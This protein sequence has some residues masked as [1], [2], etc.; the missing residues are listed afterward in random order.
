MGVAGPEPSFFFGNLLEIKRRGATACFEEWIKKYGSICGFYNGAIPFLL[1]ADVD[2]LKKVELEDCNAFMDRG[3]VFELEPLPDYRQKMIITA[4]VSRWREMRAVLSP[5]FTISKLSQIFVIM[6]KCSDTMMEKLEEKLSGNASV[7]ITSAFRRATIDTM[8][9]AGYGVDLKVQ[10]SPP[11]GFFDELGRG[12]EQLLRT[13]PVCGVSFIANCFPEFYHFWYLLSWL[14]S[15]LAVPFFMLTAKLVCPIL[16]ERKALNLGKFTQKNV[17]EMTY[18]DMVLNESMR[19]YPG[20]VGFVSR[21]PEKDYE[22]N[23]MKIPRGLSVMAAV[24]CIHQDPELWSEPD[25]FDPERFNPE[26]KPNIHPISFQP[27]GKGPRA[28]LGRNFALLEMKL[29]LSKV[30][31]RFKVSVDE[32]HH[33]CERTYASVTG[34][35]VS[36]DTADLLMDEADLEEATPQA[37]AREAQ[38]STSSSVPEGERDKQQV[39]EAS[40][41]QHEPVKGVDPAPTGRDTPPDVQ[42]PVSATE[43]GEERMDV[44]RD[45]GSSLAAK[46]SHE[47]TADS[48]PQRDDGGGGEPPT[49]TPGVRRSPYRPR[50]NIPGEPRRAGNPPP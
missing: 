13:V 18:L 25:K 6:D 24:S 36:E 15:R 28:C 29:I 30:L 42:P 39:V 34:P 10:E 14:T 3:N 26:N 45:E 16:N 35:R 2:L 12:A 37:N 50:P 41:D 38:P 47:R 17:S 8:F 22:F 4:P 23:G 44:S 27:F 1:V 7:E 48:E 11:G 43:P 31:A 32:E 19:F 49:K 33:E 9:K 20:V 21:R 40:K 5:A 46:R